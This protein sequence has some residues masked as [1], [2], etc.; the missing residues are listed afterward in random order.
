[1]GAR[2]VRKIINFSQEVTGSTALPACQL[3]KAISRISTEYRLQ[4]AWPRQAV[5]LSNGGDNVA[6]T[7][8]TAA[9]GSGPPRKSLSMGA[10]KQGIAPGGPA[11]VHKKRTVD[12]DHK[13][14]GTK[15]AI[16]QF[17]FCFVLYTT[18]EI[19][20]LLSFV[21][22]VYKR[23]PSVGTGAAGGKRRRHNRRCSPRVGRARGGCC[24]VEGNAE[25]YNITR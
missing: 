4:F 3:S 1:M 10:L 22:R 24:R 20:L 14:D 16:Q 9:A 18:L 5:Q 15:R 23:D 19:I 2:H 17:L 12:L 11:P 6:V 8:I 21:C 13:R 7:A 25:V